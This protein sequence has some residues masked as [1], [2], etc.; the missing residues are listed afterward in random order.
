MFENLHAITANIRG[1]NCCGKRQILATK[2]GKEKVDTALLS[3]T[4]KHRRYGKR[5]SIGKIHSLL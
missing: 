5:R 3:E 2:W 1:I 4:Q